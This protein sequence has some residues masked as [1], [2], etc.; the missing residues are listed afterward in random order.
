MI[1]GTILDK[2]IANK[3][4]EVAIMKQ[5]VPLE[6]VR[7]LSKGLSCGKSMKQSLLDSDTGIISE[8]KRKSPS[9]GFIKE[10][11]DVEIIARHYDLAGCS[12][13]SV[14]TDNVF[15]GGSINDLKIVKANVRCPVL[16]KDFM[17]DPY[18]I[19]QSKILGADTILLIASA[20]TLDEAYDLGALANDLGMEV[21]LEIHDE[22]E[23]DYISRYTDM[24]GVNNRNLKTFVTDVSTS[25]SLADMIP[26]D[27]VKVSE[28]GL[29]NPETVK[30]LRKAGFRGFLMGERF[31]KEDIPGEALAV[32][33]DKLKSGDEA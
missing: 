32:F 8:I 15:F 24:V 6:H 14:L 19:Y 20:L 7:T 9:L 5:S 11:A 12:A 33:I 1:M 3:R 17:I 30:E 21:L 27:K 25:Y 28:S 16:R 4:R 31:M 2:I 29:S 23:L 10:F 13:I 26:S 22:T 18:Q